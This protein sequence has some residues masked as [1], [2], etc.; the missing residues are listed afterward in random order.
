MITV[1]KVFQG[2]A[3]LM[4]E[5][6]TPDPAL[7]SG[8]Y[9]GA[10]VAM[11][12][13]VRIIEKLTTEEIFGTK[14]RAKQLERLTRGHLERLAA[15][16]PGT[17]SKVDGAGL[18]IAFLLRDGSLQAARAFIQ[19]CFA[20]GLVL[21]YGGHEPACVRLFLPVV[22]TEEELAEAFAI[23]ERCL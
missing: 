17:I 1:G 13:A 5:G 12:V 20:T 18:M 2:S 9:A 3:L 4:R 21:Y 23:M 6:F 11:A 7:M 8:T 22:I 10:T 16:H 15:S 14:G 19:H